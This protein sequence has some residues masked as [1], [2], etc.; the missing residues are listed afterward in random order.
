MS[1]YFPNGTQY[2]I[3]TTL[4]AAI[5]L[6]AITNANPAVAS[7]AA[8]PADGS[9]VVLASGWSALNDTVAKTANAAADS[10]ELAGVDTTSLVDFPA[11]AGAGTARVAG[12]WVPITQVRSNNVTGGEQQFFT[13]QYVED[14][15]NRQRQKPT[16]KSPIVITLNMDYDPALP[17]YEALIQADKLGQPVIL[18]ATLTSGD[19]I[20]YLAYPSFNKV[21]TGGLNENQQNVATFSLLGDPVRYEA[22]A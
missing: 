13:Y 7:A 20:Y 1:S 19:V 8:P 12:G 10:F 22:A 4:A 2:A 11:G 6:T 18:R 9:I 16:T 15:S 17:W 5:A 21:P 14:K 3:S